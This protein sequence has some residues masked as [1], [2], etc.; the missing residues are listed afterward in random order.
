MNNLLRKL[1]GRVFMDQAGADGGAGAGGPPAVDGG[2]PPAGADQDGGSL[3]SEFPAAGDDDPDAK[4]QG[5]ELMTP[6][7]RATKAAEKDV[8]RPKFVPA[9]FW[10]AEKGEVNFESWSKSTTEIETRMKDIGLPPKVADEYRVDAPAALKDLGVDLEPDR[11]KAFKDEAF[12]AGL[13]QKQFDFVMGK[14]FSNLEELVSHGERYDRAK[15]TRALMEHYKT[16]DVIQENV[17]A[18]YNVFSAYA[19]EEEMKHIYRVA[20]DPI[21]IRVL[22]KINKELQED[23]GVKPDQILTGESIDELMAKT[24]P[25]WDKGHPQHASIKAKVDRHF[26]AQANAAARK[27]AA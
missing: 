7:Q 18:A 19:D 21:T 4:P 1:M 17:K 9:K 25:Y 24:S 2:Q 20:N 5:D 12:S 11:V 13:T 16:Q 22:A 3:L 6:E 8:R 15:T 14:Y 26:A 23:P 10:N 27:R